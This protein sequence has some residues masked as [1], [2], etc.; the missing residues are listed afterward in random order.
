MLEVGYQ[1]PKMLFLNLH[2][3]VT[4]IIRQIACIIRG[5]KV[6]YRISIGSHAQVVV[7]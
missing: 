6:T 5:C 7:W 2:L 3:Q 1:N 4:Y